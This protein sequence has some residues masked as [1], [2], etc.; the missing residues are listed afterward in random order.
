LK[1]KPFELGDKCYDLSHLDPFSF[2]LVV[3]AKDNKPAQN[4][5]I[6]VEFS[7]HCFTRDLREGAYLSALEYSDGR[8]TRLFDEGRF[9]LSRRLPDIVRS[10]SC[11]KLFYGKDGN[12]FTVERI[13]IEG[14]VRF[15]QYAVFFKISRKGDALNFYVQSAYIPEEGARLDR[16]SSVKFSTI[17]F[18]IKNGKGF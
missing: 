15:L 14:E 3:E 7:M 16:S 1:W 2:E 9:E 11:R 6:Q 13:P 12:H 4:Y 10:V 5:Q 18:K 8:E 17:A